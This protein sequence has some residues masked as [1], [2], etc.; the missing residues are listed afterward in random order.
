MICDVSRLEFQKLY[1]RLDVTLV[2]KGESF[3]NPFMPGMV[4]VDCVFEMPV[5][6][7]VDGS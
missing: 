5:S 1:S 7:V 3:Y 6:F 2:E 4:C